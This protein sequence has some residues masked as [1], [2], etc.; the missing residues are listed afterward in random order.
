MTWKKHGANLRGCIGTFEPNLIS[1]Q[2]QK[3]AIAAA[4]HDTRFDP[5]E[6]EELPHLSCTVSVLTDFEPARDWRDW[7][8]GVHGIRIELATGYRKYHATFLP[9][10]A[11]EYDWDHEQTLRQLLI[12]SGF[13]SPVAD[14]DSLIGLSVTRYQS[15]S[16]TM[17]FDEFEAL[18][19]QQQ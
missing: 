2:L 6:R 17:S 5:I 18:R 11:A 10:V 8:V 12:K 4:F 14:L 3:Y 13:R 1:L 19:S 7:K 16:F 9:S 15:N